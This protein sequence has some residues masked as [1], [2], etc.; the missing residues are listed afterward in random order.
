MKTLLTGTKKWIVEAALA[1]VAGG[2]IYF[3]C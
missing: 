3:L 1:V 2:A